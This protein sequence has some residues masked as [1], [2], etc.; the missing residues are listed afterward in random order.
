MMKLHIHLKIRFSQSV[1]S[2]L[3]VE[4]FLQHH[5][6]HTFWVN[7]NEKITLKH[8]KLLCNVKQK[9]KLL[10]V[11]RY[12]VRNFFICLFQKKKNLKPFHKYRH[13]YRLMAKC[14]FFENNKGEKF[15]RKVFFIISSRCLCFIGHE[16]WQSVERLT[17]GKK[18]YHFLLCFKRRLYKL[19]EYVLQLYANCNKMTM[20]F[21]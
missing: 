11:F 3:L 10:S 1:F 6:T 4:F 13:K 7:V 15:V 2:L 16:T 12:S 8:L 17:E 19:P 9:C 14:R 5:A 20:Y 18:K 21:K